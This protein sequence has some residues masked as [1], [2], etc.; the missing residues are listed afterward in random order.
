MTVIHERV[1]GALRCLAAHLSVL[2]TVQLFGGP[3][4]W[5]VLKRAWKNIKVGL[6]ERLV[7]TCY[8]DQKCK[9]QSHTWHPAH[10]TIRTEDLTNN[11]ALRLRPCHSLHRNHELSRHCECS[12]AFLKG[13]CAHDTIASELLNVLKVH[14]GKLNAV[15]YKPISKRVHANLFVE[16]TAFIFSAKGN[17]R[18]ALQLLNKRPAFV[19]DIQLFTPHRRAYTATCLELDLRQC[20]RHLR[21]DVRKLFNVV[22]DTVSPV[23][24]LTLVATQRV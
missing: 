23:S 4:H 5:H 22:D 3:V 8:L 2:N 24:N 13:I 20:S 17:L 19:D 12:F 1:Q 21:H 16:L 14:T 6:K 9:R 7:S 15:L 10:Q 18:F 11:I